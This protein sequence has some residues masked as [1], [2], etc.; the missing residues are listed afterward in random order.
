VNNAGIY[1]FASLETINAEH[2]HKHFNLNVLGLLWATQEAVKHFGPR[3]RQHH[4][5]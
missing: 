2:F 1:E 4:Q 5:P 3:R